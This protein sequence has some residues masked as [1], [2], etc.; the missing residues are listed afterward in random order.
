MFEL[1]NINK[2]NTLSSVLV[3]VQAV[4][5]Y[6]LCSIRMFLRAAVIVF[7]PDAWIFLSPR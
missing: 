2:N 3:F 7:V 1:K 5:G 4:G 6:L